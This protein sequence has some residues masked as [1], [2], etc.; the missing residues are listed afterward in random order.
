M[1]RPDMR[2]VVIDSFGG[3]E[4]L[5]LTRLPRPV[6][7]PGEVQVRVAA[8]G[9]DPEDCRARRGRGA[10]RIPRF[11]AVLGWGVAGTVAAT[12]PGVHAF[13]VGD[14]VFGMPAFPRLAGAHAEYVTAHVNELAALPEEVAF[15]EAAGAT[16]AALTAWQALFCAGGLRAGQRVLVAAASGGVGH[17]A[18]QLAR[19]AG[20]EAVGAAP[21]GDHAFVKGLGAGQVVDDSEG[22]AAWQGVPFDV[23]VDAHGDVGEAAVR[24]LRPGGVLV[25][26][27]AVDA[28]RFRAQGRVARTVLVHPEGRQ[29]DRVAALLRSG[30]LRVHVDRAFRLPEVAAAHVHVERGARGSVVLEASDGGAAAPA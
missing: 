1:S 21:P 10:V 29:L 14:R 15:R 25:S 8:A 26:A 19:W 11:P 24:L 4:V 5:R 28:D 16:A 22:V 17:L 30:E 18:V 3:P 12:G 9:V 2:A 20:A 27:A 23:V 13:A 7:G 6:P